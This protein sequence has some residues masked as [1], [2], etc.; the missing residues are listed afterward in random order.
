MH[1]KLL[2]PKN[3]RLG[4]P[5]QVGAL[6]AL[7]KLEIFQKL[8]DHSPVM[9]GALALGVDVPSSFVEVN[10]FSENLEVFAEK[11]KSIY[12]VQNRFALEYGMQ[13]VWPT[14]VAKFVHEDFSFMITAQGRTVF[15]QPAVLHLLVEA[16][17]LAFS[18]AEARERV[19][20]LKA[21]GATT[22]EAFADC[23]GLEGDANSELLKIAQLPDHE[24]LHIAHRFLFSSQ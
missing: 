19:R 13:A 4:T 8:Q 1:M 22:E 2:D 6:Q 18:P 16:R 7:E 12:G 5:R 23:Y 20:Q 21:A 9:S 10:C 17:L 3:L 15:Q 14:V 24:I 11:I